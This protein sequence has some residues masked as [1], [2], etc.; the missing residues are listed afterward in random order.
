MSFQGRKL[1]ARSTSESRNQGEDVLIVHGFALLL[2]TP[3]ASVSPKGGM[4]VAT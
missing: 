2:E 4:T 3:L 1:L